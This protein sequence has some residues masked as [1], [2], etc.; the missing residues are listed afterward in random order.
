MHRGK[1][2]RGFRK[3][4]VRRAGQTE[5]RNILRGGTRL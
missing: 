4:F 5:R 2:G 3:K 1:A